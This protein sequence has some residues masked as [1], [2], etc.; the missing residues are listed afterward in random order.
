MLFDG[1]GTIKVIDKT[2]L[3]HSYVIYAIFAYIFVCRISLTQSI[4]MK[5]VI[6]GEFF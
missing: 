1:N 6:F 3:A 4:E 2:C 5:T